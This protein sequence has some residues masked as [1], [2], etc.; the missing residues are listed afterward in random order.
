MISNRYF[1]EN[2]ESSQKTETNGTHMSLKGRGYQD[3]VLQLGDEF[4]ASLVY[5]RFYVK[6]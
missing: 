5:K 6:R 1:L 3:Q 2:T 4:K